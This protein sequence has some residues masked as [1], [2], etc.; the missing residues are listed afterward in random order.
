MEISMNIKYMTLGLLGFVFMSNVSMAASPMEKYLSKIAIFENEDG[1]TIKSFEDIYINLNPFQ[2][3]NKK[4]PIVNTGKI[5]EGYVSEETAKKYFKDFSKHAVVTDEDIDFE[6]FMNEHFSIN[7]ITDFPNN[8]YETKPGSLTYTL[9]MDDD[10]KYVKKFSEYPPDAVSCRVDTSLCGSGCEELHK[11]EK[12]I[13]S[14]FKNNILSKAKIDDAKEINDPQNCIKMS[15][16][17]RTPPDISFDDS[18]AE[19]YNGF[20]VLGGDISYEPCTSGDWYLTPKGILIGREKPPVYHAKFSF[21]RFKDCPENDKDWKEFEDWSKL[22]NIK[23]IDYSDYNTDSKDSK[24]KNKLFKTPKASPNGYQ[25]FRDV[26]KFEPIDG[27]I[28]YSIFVKEGEID[29]DLPVNPSVLVQH[30]RPEIGYGYPTAGDLGNTLE[31]AKDWP[32]RRKFGEVTGKGYID[33]ILRVYDNDRPNII[34]RVTNVETNEQ[35]F[36]PPCVASSECKISLSSKYKAMSGK[37]KTNQ[38]DYAWFVENL[39]PDYNHTVIA[40]V[41]DLKPYYTIYSIND[42]NIKTKTE[43]SYV[44]RLLFNKDMK[45]I[46]ENVR[47]EDYYFSDRME[48]GSPTYSADS[49]SKK[50]KGSFGK[51][52]GTCCEMAALYENTSGFRFKTGVEY[53]LDVWTDDNVKWTNIEYEKSIDGG[54]EMHYEYVKNTGIKSAND[55]SIPD[56]TSDN[57]IQLMVGKPKLLDEARVYDTGIKKGII[58]LNIPND[59]ENLNEEEKIDITK[60][61]NGGIYFTLKDGTSKIYN[62]KTA[63]E[64]ESNHFPSIFVEAEDF[65]GLKR[66]LRLFFRVDDKNIDIKTLENSI[67]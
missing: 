39:G 40:G 45:F 51:R 21:G 33:G 56:D 26:V 23:R 2:K 47:V 5:P 22:E 31:T 46:N 62:M 50:Y 41:P 18:L 28:R 38:D 60:H 52:R 15:L 17:K 6:E 12:N 32:D 63:K 8:Y 42:T 64:L 9:C 20:P 10:Y 66:R 36:F 35:M 16:V 24:Y 29:S 67:K 49:K 3:R 11:N 57:H 19:E 37:D 34:I 7:E 30:N 54:P 25:Y 13:Y 65:S 59:S 4:F 43:D 44:D 14:D 1:R 53:K 61:I 58:K 48:D 27:F 55:P